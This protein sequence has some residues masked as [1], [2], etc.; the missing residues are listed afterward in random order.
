[1]KRLAV[2]LLVIIAVAVSQSA[3]AAYGYQLTVPGG[4]LYPPKY[5]SVKAPVSLDRL[6]ANETRVGVSL[7]AIGA[8]RLH[9]AHGRYALSLKTNAVPLNASD[10]TIYIYPA[11]GYYS[12]SLVANATEVDSTRVVLDARLRLNV[13]QRPV[14]LQ[15]YVPTANDFVASH[16]AYS[17]LR[18]SPSDYFADV[19]P[20]FGIAYMPIRGVGRL[21]ITT[22]R[23]IYVIVNGRPGVHGD[24]VQLANGESA[25]FVAYVL[26]LNNASLPVSV[27]VS[28]QPITTDTPGQ[29]MVPGEQAYVY[30]NKSLVAEVKRD[31]YVIAPYG[32]RATR[33]TLQANV[34]LKP[35]AI[36]AD[37]SSAVAYI[38]LDGYLL[39]DD[40]GYGMRLSLDA[41][42]LYADM[43]VNVS[44]LLD[45]YA[46]VGLVA[47]GDFTS[48]VRRTFNEPLAIAD[49]QI[50]IN[51]SKTGAPSGVIAI[52]GV[53][54]VSVPH[55]SLTAD[56]Y[57]RDGKIRFALIGDRRVERPVADAVSHG[58]LKLKLTLA[59]RR[60]PFIPADAERHPLN[61]PIGEL[62]DRQGHVGVYR[63]SQTVAV[64]T[65][66]KAEPPS[67]MKPVGIRFLPGA[68]D[69]NDIETACLQAYAYKD[70]AFR[71]NVSMPIPTGKP[72]LAIRPNVQGVSLGTPFRLFDVKLYGKRRIGVVH[73]GESQISLYGARL[74]VSDERIIV[75][76]GG[77]ATVSLKLIAVRL[78]RRVGELPV[79]LYDA[80]LKFITKKLIRRD[81]Y[82]LVGFNVTPNGVMPV[83]V[84]LKADGFSGWSAISYT[85]SETPAGRAYVADI[86]SLLAKIAGGLMY[87]VRLIAANRD[88]IF[89]FMV[90]LLTITVLMVP[91]LVL[92]AIIDSQSLVA[93]RQ[94]LQAILSIVQTAVSIFTALALMALVKLA[95]AITAVAGAMHDALGSFGRSLKAFGRKLKSLVSRIAPWTLS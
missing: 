79:S 4:R 22:E 15:L 78:E 43:H 57:V 75:L 86:K 9:F 90:L 52:K 37:G 21:A 71:L 93:G 92:I 46:G 51:A 66:L 63:V 13:S 40:A 45:G 72:I 95:A 23:P 49:G 24:P 44:L 76:P 19:L 69:R 18:L 83:E 61:K 27:G 53:F 74:N 91:A 84:R 94:R 3:V 87:A 68:V 8:C 67:P 65:S 25:E 5:L 28:F 32:M 81:G 17:L 77:N 56:A 14:W 7:Q 36:L 11:D 48:D 42:L 26:L 30:Y 31:G 2:C 58:Q 16:L 60:T 59:D 85:A 80:G 6:V 10:L 64:P 73:E 33:T 1:M 82:R 29:L 34:P 20:P 50:A 88:M 12:V 47:Y 38:R 39:R 70:Y 35:K 54:G 55:L 62:V 41:E 89:V